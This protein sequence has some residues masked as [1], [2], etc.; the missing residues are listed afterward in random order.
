M[1]IKIEI[2]EAEILELGQHLAKRILAMKCGLV[3][4][5]FEDKILGRVYDCA[6]KKCQR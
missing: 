3:S 1:K 6:R 2:S 4:P 5:T